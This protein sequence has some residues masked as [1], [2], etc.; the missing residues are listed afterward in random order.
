VKLKREDPKRLDSAF[1][2]GVGAGARYPEFALREL[3]S[4][5]GSETWTGA[6]GAHGVA[7]AMGRT[8]RRFLSAT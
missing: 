4:E 6:T 5:R 8:R 7:V 1:P 2:N 3:D